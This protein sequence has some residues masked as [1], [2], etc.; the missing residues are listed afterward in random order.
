MQPVEI[1][2]END[3]NLEDGVHVDQRAR[4]RFTDPIRAIYTVTGPATRIGIAL[5]RPR[6]EAK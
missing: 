2:G 4:H 5:E 3:G 6:R 1:R